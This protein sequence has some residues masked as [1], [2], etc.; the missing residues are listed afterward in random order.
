MARERLNASWKQ[1][2]PEHDSTPTMSYSLRE[3]RVYRR[4]WDDAYKFRR[5]GG[6]FVGCDRAIQLGEP[7]G[8]DT[9][10]SRVGRLSK[11]GAAV[12]SAVQQGS[13]VRPIG[14]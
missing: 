8:R 13:R 10:P 14:G 9:G 5:N 12:R 2:A 7:G 4:G 3:A 1:V 11:E 6:E